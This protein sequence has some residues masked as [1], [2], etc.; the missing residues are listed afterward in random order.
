MDDGRW[1]T[2][3]L[4]G[5]SLE[6]AG[7]YAL[8]KSPRHNG[9]RTIEL[10]NND[11]ANR[12]LLCKLAICNL[13]HPPELLPTPLYSSRSELGQG[14]ILSSRDLYSPPIDTFER[15]TPAYVNSQYGYNDC[16]KQEEAI[17]H[18][19]QGLE[20]R[21]SHHSVHKEQA[22]Q[23]SIRRWATFHQTPT[24]AVLLLDRSRQVDAPSQF[25]ASAS[26]FTIWYVRRKRLPGPWLTIP[27]LYG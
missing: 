10:K 4:D 16:H 19:R 13:S 24:T 3:L 17:S 9:L 6:T 1:L 11:Q 27:K 8:Q 14:D 2:V 25:E 15:L 7:R 12:R 22:L 26:D 23:F 20:R 21:R 18:H 5:C